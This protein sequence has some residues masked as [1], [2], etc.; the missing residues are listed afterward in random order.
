MKIAAYVKEAAEALHLPKE[1]REVMRTISYDPGDEEWY[2]TYHEF[3]E[4]AIP[5]EVF[6]WTLRLIGW[7]QFSYP[8]GPAFREV[9]CC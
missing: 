6:F 5:V 7:L 4:S 8:Q 3:P 1:L 9:S 2:S